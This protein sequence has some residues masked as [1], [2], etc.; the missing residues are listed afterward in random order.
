MKKLLSNIME[1]L[2]LFI[3][4]FIFLLL[5]SPLTDERCKFVPERD[6]ELTEEE[7]KIFKGK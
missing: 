2:G 7:M 5:V 6:L 1:L 4:L 3:V